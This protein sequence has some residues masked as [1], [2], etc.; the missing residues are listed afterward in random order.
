MKTTTFLV[1][2]LTEV[3]LFLRSLGYGFVAVSWLVIKRFIA[4]FRRHGLRSRPLYRRRGR[5]SYYR[6][7]SRRYDLQ[8]ARMI[9]HFGRWLG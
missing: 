6:V 8:T 5:S 4:F 1:R 2:M 9:R 3:Y 7:R